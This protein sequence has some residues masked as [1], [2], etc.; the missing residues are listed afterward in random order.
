[1]WIW[2]WFA[3][4]W[5]RKIIS[6]Q[7]EKLCTKTRFE[8]AVRATLEWSLAWSYFQYDHVQRPTGEPLHIDHLG[9]GGSRE[10]VQGVHPPP[11]PWDDLP[12]SYSLLNLFTSGHQSATPFLS[13]AP[14]LLKRNPGSALAWVQESSRCRK[15]PLCGDRRRGLGCNMTPGFF[16]V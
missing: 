3:R 5:P 1:M 4:Q 9:R 11:P 15:G 10:R 8:T 13:G 16:G 12:S 7:Y 6:F 14:P 2:V